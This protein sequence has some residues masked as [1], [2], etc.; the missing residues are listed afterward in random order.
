MLAWL[1][2]RA[3]PASLPALAMLGAGLVAFIGFALV[4]VFVIGPPSGPGT[5]DVVPVTGWSGRWASGA[6]VLLGTLWT[7][8][9]LRTEGAPRREPGESRA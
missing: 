3:E 8:R 7:V 1:V 4:A 6:V 2:L 9:S 5:P